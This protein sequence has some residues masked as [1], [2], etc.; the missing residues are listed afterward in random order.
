MR[1]TLGPIEG[2][3]DG[4]EPLPV[5]GFALGRG[6]LRRELAV[7]GPVAGDVGLVCPSSRRPGRRGRRRR[8][9]WFRPRRGGGRRVPSMSAWNCISALLTA[10]AAVDFQAR[11]AARRRPAAW[12]RAGRA[13]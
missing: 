10:G 11:P 6:H 9:R 2:A 12:L 1:L 4:F 5:A 13:I 3:L 7:E 8:G